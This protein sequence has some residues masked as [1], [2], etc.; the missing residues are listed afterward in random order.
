MYL[1]LYVRRAWVIFD[2]PAD[3]V[4]WLAGWLVVGAGEQ[5]RWLWAS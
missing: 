3:S 5:I 2:L 4:R 1:A